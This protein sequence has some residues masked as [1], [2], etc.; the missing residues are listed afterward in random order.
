MFTFVGVPIVALI[1]LLTG[2]FI[3][4]FIMVFLWI[5]FIRF[6]IGPIIGILVSLLIGLLI[7]SIFELRYIPDM[8]FFLWEAVFITGGIAL[9][10]KYGDY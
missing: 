3:V 7:I 6:V 1:S 8:A 4:F 5:S 10:W 2:H 9:A